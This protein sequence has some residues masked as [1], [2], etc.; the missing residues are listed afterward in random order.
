MPTKKKSTKKARPTG[1]QK[2]SAASQGP[3]PKVV[4]ALDRSNII[5][6]ILIRGIPFPDIIKGKFTVRDLKQATTTLNTLFG[7]K[8]AEYK[9]VKLFPKGIPVIDQITIEIDGK[10]RR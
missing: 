5:H 1:S 7:I 3:L 6:D 8:N 4:A 2:M 10:V 9:P